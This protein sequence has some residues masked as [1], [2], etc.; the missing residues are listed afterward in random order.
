MKQPHRKRV[1]GAKPA[2]MVS[3]T[4]HPNVPIDLHHSPAKLA[5]WGFGCV[6]FVI[7]SI[8]IIVSG[9]IEADYRGRGA[10]LVHWMGP[11]GTLA[12]VGLVGT[13]CAV[14]SA[15]YLRLLIDA[16]RLAASATPAGLAINGIWGRKSYDWKDVAAIHSHVVRP[17]SKEIV[18]IKI[19]QVE[20]RDQ[21][22]PTGTIDGGRGTV[23]AWIQDTQIY[24]ATFR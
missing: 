11:H 19:E 20:G 4:D 23:E 18:F 1:F 17:R 3:P 6:A 10:A 22:V 9:G 16:E 24:L 8:W 7:L 13:S 2:T 5:I 21:L 14:L 12:L 15:A